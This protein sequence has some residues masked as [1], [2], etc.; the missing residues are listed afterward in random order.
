MTQPPT[1]TCGCQPA[2]SGPS[3]PTSERSSSP[4]DRGDPGAVAGRPAGTV[5]RRAA[6]AGSAAA[7]AGM[8]LT[9]C[10][11]DSGTGAATTSAPAT[12]S[13]PAGATPSGTATGPETSAPEG[14]RLAST[15]DI[16]VG[17]GTI[18]TA[19]VGTVVVTH[20]ADGEFKAFNGKCPHQGCPVASVADDTITCNCHGSTFDAVT[21]DRTGGPAMVGLEPLDITVTG[22]AVY[23]T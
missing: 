20:P 2:G 21:G 7:V 16:A 17:G 10:S 11:S 5:T 15:A 3:R 9:G 1:C 12:T 19:L 6:I 8:A 23:L 4:A 22:D 14:E 13:G 18:L